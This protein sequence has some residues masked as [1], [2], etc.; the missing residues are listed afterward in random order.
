MTV[1]NPCAVVLSSRAPV[2]VAQEIL[3]AGALGDS[4]V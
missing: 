2:G 4:V 1:K 3:L